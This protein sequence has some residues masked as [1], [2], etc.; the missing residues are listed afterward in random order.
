MLFDHESKTIQDGFTGLDSLTLIETLPYGAR[1]STEA[2]ALEVCFFAPGMIRLRL[3][4]TALPEYGLLATGQAADLD[5]V[6]EETPQGYRICSGDTTLE[7]LE[8]PIRFVLKQAG[9]TRLESVTD[10]SFQGDLRW[11]PLARSEEAWLFS[12]ALRSGHA[13]YGLGEKFGPLNRRGQLVESWNTDATTVNSE[14]SYKNVPFAWSPAGWGIFTHTTSRVTHAVGHPQWSHRSYILRIE[15]PNLDL[16]LFTAGTPAEM[17]EAYTRL[18]GRA[19]APPRWSLGAWMSRAYYKTAGEI[20]QVGRELRRRKIPCDVLTLDGRAWHKMETRFN[21][22][23]DADRYPDPAAFLQ[24]MREDNYKICL[25]EYPYVSTKSALHT[26]LADKGFLLKDQEG[27]PYL[28]RWLPAPLDREYPHLQPSGI[29]DFTN[30][31]A[32]RWYQEAH[33][34]LFELGASVMKTDYGESIPEDVVAFNGDTG[35]R[36][37]NVYALLYNQCVYEATQKYSPDGPLVWGRAGWAGSQRIPLQWGGDPQCD[38]EGLAASIRGGLSYGLSGVP[39]YSHDIGGFALGNPP[40]DLYIRWTQAG[41]MMSHTRFHGS[42]EREPWVYG[43]EAERIIR[44]WLNWRY[45]LIPYLQAC[46]LE[47]GRSGMPVM[48]A[49]PLAFPQD[50]SAWGFEEQYMLGPSLLV[51]PVLVPESRVR[52]Y[53]PAGGWINLWNG[54]RYEGPQVIERDVPLDQIPLFGREGRILPLGPPVQHT[55]QLEAGLHLKEIMTFGTPQIGMR[56]PGLNLSVSEGKITP[57]SQEVPVRPW[58]K[59]LRMEASAI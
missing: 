23:W 34:P 24:K 44:H 38:W 7:V 14:R 8:S 9:E 28:H 22:E 36:L 37:H 43:E 17:L 27:L 29:I 3:T 18:T 10:R 53:L 20:E 35:R 41:V 33:R 4:V 58:E 32:Y 11:L 50:P 31:E 42:G 59:G 51:V 47:A 1:F 52:L 49:M 40:P 54:D 19:P 2:G 45:R 39:F 56:L 12:M 6:T 30:P 25:W 5:V 57:L 55:G 48:R 13:V 15:D 21:F 46:A 16:F 26:E